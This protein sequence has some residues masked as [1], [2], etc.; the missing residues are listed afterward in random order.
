MIYF[1]SFAFMNSV[2]FE[3]QKYTDF[4]EYKL[5]KPK[6]TEKEREI[7]LN[8]FTNNSGFPV[9]ENKSLIAFA[10]MGGIFGEGIDLIGDKL[11]GCMIVTVGLPFLGGENEL[12]K[13]YY[14]EAMHKGFEYAYRY[15][16]FNKVMQAAGRV[17]RSETDKG[18]VVLID[19]R[20]GKIEYKEIGDAV[21]AE[22]L[23]REMASSLTW[24]AVAVGVSLLWGLVMVARV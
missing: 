15:P 21:E 5:Q 16:G 12:I 23:D 9:G 17:I 8:H 10:I 13:N 2:M 22:S 18:I 1:P 7:F 20:Y 14:D 19:H 4:A 24:C 3:S 11:I 6:M